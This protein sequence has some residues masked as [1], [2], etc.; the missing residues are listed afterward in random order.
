MIDANTKGRTRGSA[1]VPAL[2]L[3][4]VLVVLTTVLLD[5]SSSH[6]EVVTGERERRSAR[7]L[8]RAGLAEA[9]AA[10][11][12]GRSGAV[13]TP[14]LPARLGDGVLWVTSEDLG[15]GRHRLRSTA[16]AGS[17]RAA[18]E[19]IA[20]VGGGLGDLFR[21][22]LNAKDTLTLNEGVLVDSYDSSLGSYDSQSGN[23]TDG[24]V[25]AGTNGDV[26]SNSDIVVNANAHVFGDA[27]PGPGHSVSFGTGGYVHGSTA[28]AEEPFDFPTFDPPQF[29][30]S[31][32]LD[33]SASHTLGPGEYQFDDVTIQKDAVLQVKGP[34]TIVVD[35]TFSGMKDADLVIDSID[36]PVTIYTTDYSHGKGFEATPAADSPMAVAFLVTGPNGIEFPSGSSIRGAYYA[37]N[38]DIVFSNQSEA[39]GSFVGDAI[40]M[41]SD[42]KFHYDEDLARHWEGGE[43]DDGVPVDQL[44]WYEAAVDPALTSDRRD[45]FTLLGVAAAELPT[46]A[47]SWAD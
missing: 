31:G 33:V 7:S 3:M 45:P 23:I 46:P 14:D 39:W 22:T 43:G 1:L 37:Q 29:G 9:V 19:M 38:A 26:R 21:A 18:F 17:G 40:S 6:S 41:S 25:H 24:V 36:G 20:E 4:S 35:G 10:A 13:A 16:M 28:P 32:P 42:M 15:D 34:A 44:A 47:E 2:I 12:S 30:S 8:A 27:T 11:R 5:G